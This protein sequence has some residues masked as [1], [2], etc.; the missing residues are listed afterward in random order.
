MKESVL[1]ANAEV[2]LDDENAYAAY[3]P[4]QQAIFCEVKKGFIRREDF[5]NLF[6]QVGKAAKL[7]YPERIIFDKSKMRVF[8]Q[9]SMTWYHTVWKAD[10]LATIRFKKYRKILPDDVLFKTSVDIG[11]QR[12]AKEHHFDFEKYD[13]QYCHTIE[14]ALNS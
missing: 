3:L 6:H 4:T 14:E 12:I 11:R 1:F 9:P 7:K 5:E 2:I 13:I 8:D 10:L